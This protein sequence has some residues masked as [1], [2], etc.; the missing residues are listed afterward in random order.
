[1]F[2]QMQALAQKQVRAI[3]FSK[4]SMYNVHRLSL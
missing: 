2:Q 1:M 3:G 4:D